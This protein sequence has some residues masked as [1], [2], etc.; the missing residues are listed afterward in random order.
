MRVLAENKVLPPYY[1]I[2]IP[3]T[4]LKIYLAIALGFLSATVVP[5]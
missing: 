5:F 1:P 3:L 2:N 4:D